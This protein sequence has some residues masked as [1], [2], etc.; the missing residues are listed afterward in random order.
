MSL[1]WT[2]FSDEEILKLGQDG[3]DSAIDFLMERYKNLV[4]KKART[5]YLVGGDNDDLIQEGMIGLYKATRDYSLEKGVSFFHFAELCITRQLYNA[6]KASR[7][8]KNTPLN[9]YISLYTPL[10]NNY[11]ENET[12]T[13]ADTLPPNEILDPEAI[14]IDKEAVSQLKQ[15][16]QEQLSPFENNVMTLFLDGVDYQN[17]AILLNRTPK[18]IDNALQRIRTKLKNQN[19]R[20][21]C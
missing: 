8:L 1:D 16:L 4:R 5:L 19:P 12:T 21:N 10:Q 14:M 18:S 11:S 15:V 17:I 6:V 20:F 7:R 13:L 3:D 9:S 2:T